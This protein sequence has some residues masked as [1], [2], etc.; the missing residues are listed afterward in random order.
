MAGYELILPEVLLL[1]GALAVLFADLFAPTSHK[2]A[3]GIGAVFSLAAT[4]AAAL[5]PVGLVSPFGE[6]LAFD[7]LGRFACVAS[8]ALTTIWLIWT[9]G[10]GEGQVKEAVSL[11]LFATLGAFLLASAQELITVFVSL[12]LS[13][14]PLYVLIGYRRNDIR[15]LEGAI[16]YFLLSLLTTMV[17]LYGFSFLYGMTG[18]TYYSG[19]QI[20]FTNPSVLVVM[21]LCLVGIFAKL[22]AAPFH[23]W[24]PDAYDGATAWSVAYVSTVPKIAGVIMLSRFVQALAPTVS[25]VH[26]MIAVVAGLSMILG[27][28]A[29]L[30]QNDVRR[31][32]AYSSVA[33]AGYLLLGIVVTTALGAAVAVIYI[34]VYSV[35]T[36]G[37]ML[38]TAEEGPRVADF[39][40][41]AYRRPWAAWG[42]VIML[43]SLIGIPPV[44]GFFGKLYLFTAA[45]QQGQLPLVIIAIV[46]SV[47]SGGYYLRIV[48]AMFF[49]DPQEVAD[50]PAL[51]PSFGGGLA[52]VAC[53]VLTVG[54]GLGFGMV[55]S[56]MVPVLG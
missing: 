40:N 49:G 2:A 50:K 41:L 29:A 7:E 21:A 48:Y 27:N 45:L 36:M 26:L 56:T 12:E 28:L 33:H 9:A 53:V 18:T 55:L 39:N 31:M 52:V 17:T 30:L 6:L 43:L 54:L 47:V 51:T 14:L 34:V 38:V 16:K 44:A 8:G 10:R 22:S 46:M 32:M 1:V 19:L 15:G 13:T 24:A 5:I 3:A 37:I 20:P 23:Y 35:A 42:T 4:I 25:S 11:V